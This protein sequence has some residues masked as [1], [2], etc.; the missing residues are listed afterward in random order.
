MRVRL[1]T[2]SI[3]V[4]IAMAAACSE[5]TP[6]SP[7]AV[8]SGTVATA[9]ASTGRTPVP[10]VGELTG[11][12]FEDQTIPCLGSPAPFAHVS[13]GVGTVS[14][15][16]LTNVRSE[17]CIVGVNQNGSLR[18]S[19]SAVFRA[20]NGDEVHAA[21]SGDLY[22]YFPTPAPGALLTASGPM[23]VTGGTGRFDS[24]SGKGDF[25]VEVIVALPPMPIRMTVNASI[26]Y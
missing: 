12:T 8:P 17:H 22:G 6:M 11:Q 9:A 21:Y 25:R 5:R 15:L 20:A 19:G 10:L 1:A 24:A 4:V 18:I 13:E 14:H 26:V 23:V 3:V 7:S 2:F 16:G